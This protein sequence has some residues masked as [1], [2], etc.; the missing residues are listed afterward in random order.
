M[1]TLIVLMILQEVTL[2]VFAQDS[3]NKMMETRAREFHRA[4]E[5]DDRE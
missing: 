1:R 4:I 3:R 2:G 5:L